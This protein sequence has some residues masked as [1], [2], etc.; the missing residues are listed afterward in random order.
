[1]KLTLPNG[2]VYTAKSMRLYELD[3]GEARE[4]KRYTG[5]T[6]ADWRL[7]LLT[8][9]RHDPDI[10]AGVVWLLMKRAGDTVHWDELNMIPSLELLRGFDWSDDVAEM[11]ADLTE[12]LN[13][14][15]DP[16]P[17]TA[18]CEATHRF[19]KTG[20]PRRCDRETGHDGDHRSGMGKTQR[21]WPASE[22]A[23]N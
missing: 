1:V 3:L 20:R 22:P 19:A 14:P 10:L 7:G 6:L 4:I 2:R 12:L 21:E 5:L 11:Q 15:V 8:F 13:Q 16:P 17:A 9:D 23:L 18:R